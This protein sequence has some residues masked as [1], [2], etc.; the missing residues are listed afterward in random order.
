MRG[1]LGSIT[2]ET[3]YSAILLYSAIVA[4]YCAILIESCSTLLLYQVKTFE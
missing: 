3:H 4:A 1:S 2:D